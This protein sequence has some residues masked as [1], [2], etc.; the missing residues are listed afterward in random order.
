[1]SCIQMCFCDVSGPNLKV[2]RNTE[3]RKRKWRG[4]RVY[5]YDCTLPCSSKGKEESH[6]TYHDFF[7]SIKSNV[8]KLSAVGHIDEFVIFVT[9]RLKCTVVFGKMQNGHPLWKGWEVESLRW[10]GNL[11]EVQLC[12][13]LQIFW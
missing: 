8:R 12:K 13:L 11:E 6:S 1:M 7:P 2:R 10:T 9:H 3:I 5:C 4:V